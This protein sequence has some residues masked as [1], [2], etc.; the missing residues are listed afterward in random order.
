MLLDLIC[1]SSN[2]RFNSN[3]A[4]ILGLHPSIYIS[5][6][7]DIN[8]KA[9][10]KNK[11]NNN[12]FKLDRKY[13]KDKSTL[14]YDEQKEIDELLEKLS[15]ISKQDDDHICVNITAITTIMM[16]PDESLITNIKKIIKEKSAAKGPK[17]TKEEV[18]TQNL[19]A[20]ITCTNPEL[21]I[22]YMDW[23]DAVM[24]K[25]H[26]M[27]AKAVT[28]A[29]ELIDT[30]TNRNLDLALK[31]LNIASINGYRDIQ[32][33]INVYEKDIRSQVNFTKTDYTIPN[34]TKRTASTK[35]DVSDEVF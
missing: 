35:E 2:V 23:I 7:L 31:L 5:L 25:Q 28:S 10:K 13:V 11:I 3:L 21:N 8:N 32:W 17:L 15:I 18:L 26:W 16:S 9:I 27:S 4:Q 34:S 29:Q 33:A 6:L 19:K 24:A 22:A 14:S 30:Y 12:Y 20:K 1:D